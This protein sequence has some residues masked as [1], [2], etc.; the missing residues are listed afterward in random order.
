[1]AIQIMRKT[2]KSNLSRFTVCVVTPLFLTTVMSTATLAAT[3]GINVSPEPGWI[4]LMPPVIAIGIALIFRSVIPALF[5]GI[6]FGA[7]IIA[8][9]GLFSGWTSFLK[10]F[11]TYLVN[12]IADPDRVRVLLFTMMLGGMIGILARNGGMQG[13]VARVTRFASTAVRG[14]LITATLGLVIF[15]DDIANT[16]LIGKTMRPVTDKLRISREKLAYL[17]DSTAAPVAGIAFAS[18]WVGF[19]VSVIGSTIE[20]VS[21]L[22][23]SP[24]LIFLGSVPYSFY[25]IITVFMVFAVAYT[26]RDF[27]PMYEAEIAA[28]RAK[29]ENAAE[30]AEVSTTSAGIGD[31]PKASN[32]IVPILIVVITLF[33]GLLISGSGGTLRDILS[34]AD[35][36]L[37]L[38]WASLL[39]VTSAAII[40]VYHKI[41]TVNEVIDAWSEGVGS[42]LF[43]VIVLVLSWTLADIVQLL[44][45]AEYIIA[46][47][48]GNLPLYLLPTLS[49]LLSGI[50]AFTTGTS[51]GTLGIMMPL[52]LPLSWSLLTGSA[53]YAVTDQMYLFHG[54]IGGVLAGA[55]FGD[56]CSPIS[57]TTVLSSLASDCDHIDHVRTQ[58]PYALTCAL[59]AIFLGT[60]PVGL[61]VPWWICLPVSFV[62]V[63]MILKTIGKSTNVATPAS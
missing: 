22:D 29:S 26:A 46:I 36:Y 14:Q 5:I 44:K 45:T 49:F 24:Y 25:P 2:A 21:D 35:S 23:A 19:E 38:M 59:C 58:L 9:P 28:R 40:T 18:T 47:A 57:D 3:S 55:I 53:D 8:G 1:M 13:V 43:A 17:V 16:L 51:W 4:T 54:S 7:F 60:L 62:A 32:A 30:S 6:W 31:N 42:T 41:L 52:I 39:G 15:F 50:V 20:G 61:G 27:G 33:A 12:A 56:H 48:S 10:S 34:S 11:D 37:A 63:F